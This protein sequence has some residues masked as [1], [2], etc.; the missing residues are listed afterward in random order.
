ML[1]TYAWRQ[2]PEEIGAEIRRLLEELADLRE[3][4]RETS[5]KEDDLVSQLQGALGYI[6]RSTQSLDGGIVTAPMVLIVNMYNRRFR[7]NLVD[8][9]VYRKERIYT[10]L[11][12]NQ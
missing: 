4:Q 6:G 3:Q 5:S 12:Y 1:K 9:S 2:P 11:L 7:K 8:R 10:L